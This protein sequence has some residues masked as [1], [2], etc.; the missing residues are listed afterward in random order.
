MSNQWW[1]RSWCHTT[2]NDDVT[3]LIMTSL[4]MTH[5]WWCH[6]TYLYTL[7]RG[8]LL[9]TVL[10]SSPTC[11]WLR[12]WAQA[13]PVQHLQ[14][15]LLNCAL[16]GLASCWKVEVLSCF[17]F[18]P[19]AWRFGART[20][21]FLRLVLIPSRAVLLVPAEELPLQSVMLPPSCSNVGSAVWFLFQTWTYGKISILV[22][23]GP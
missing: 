6:T 11:L 5:Y 9:G 7:Y 10:S 3:P 17:M 20:D 15:L 22:P 19:E 16:V 14:Q 13:G 21:W 2:D 4:M 1:W 23:S 8:H 18:H 12:L